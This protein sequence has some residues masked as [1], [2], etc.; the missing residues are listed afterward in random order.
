MRLDP[1]AACQAPQWLDESHGAGNDI[2]ITSQ[3]SNEA[4]SA[5]NEPL[6]RNR[7]AELAASI[8][9][10]DAELARLQA[11]RCRLG[12]SLDVVR[13][14]LS[15]VR[16]VPA[17]IWSMIFEIYGLLLKPHLL[18]LEMTQG[19][20][21]HVPL[22]LVCPQW[23]RIVV[24]TPSLWSFIALDMGTHQC[25][26]VDVAQRN[27][28]LRLLRSRSCLLDVVVD[29]GSSDAVVPY[30]PILERL[31][32]ESGRI[33][34]L[35]L[36]LGGKLPVLPNLAMSF[37][38][39]GSLT[40]DGRWTGDLP[41]TLWIT[42]TR[43]TLHSLSIQRLNWD[44]IRFAWNWIHDLRTDCATQVME[45]V[46]DP[47]CPLRELELAGYYFE[48]FDS[49]LSRDGYDPPDVRNSTLRSLKINCSHP[50][51]DI[52]LQRLQLPCLEELSL[53]NCDHIQWRERIGQDLPTFLSHANIQSLTLNIDLSDERGILQNILE[54]SLPRLR[55]LH[56]SD[57]WTN[58]D[59]T[60]IS[61]EHEHWFEF[62]LDV[63]HHHSYSSVVLPELE[64]ITYRV[65]PARF[66]GMRS[67]FLS[68]ALCNDALFLDF[69][70][71]VDDLLKNRINSRPSASKLKKLVLNGG[72]RS[73][74]DFPSFIR[75]IDAYKRN[76]LIFEFDETDL[77]DM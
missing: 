22:M 13:S 37:E 69:L 4:P 62:P 23:R 65:F 9:I 43:A 41:E 2:E 32:R 30:A 54:N 17:E 15:A 36:D 76:G 45:R 6:L 25:L 27:V 39:L 16:R 3:V 5:R 71:K 29:G 38:Q 1:C 10:A 31:L 59:M 11:V 33:N 70:Q 60:P 73:L 49:I 74:D 8:A 57:F 46:G 77:D 18:P 52:L 66:R 21:A 50:G 75:A 42:L 72:G 24:S 14:R 19:M 26:P 20:T 44:H 68:S 61:Q 7:E 67:S 58:R 55:S 12:A 63:I 64:T 48:H 53:T 35:V 47:A 28:D 51:S 56:I 40:I 34:S